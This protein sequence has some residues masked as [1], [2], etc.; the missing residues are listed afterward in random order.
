MKE[1]ETDMQLR[2]GLSR[3]QILST[4]DIFVTSLHYSL[5][6]NLSSLLP[7]DDPSTGCRGTHS[8]R[9]ARPMG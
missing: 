9:M 6:L 4:H 1:G 5:M 7:R 3:D 2:G 8:V